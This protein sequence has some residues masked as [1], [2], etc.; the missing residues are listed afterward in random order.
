MDNRFAS[1]ILTEMTEVKKLE[2]SLGVCAE[3][4]KPKGAEKFGMSPEAIKSHLKNPY[5]RKGFHIQEG[6]S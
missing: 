3:V 6:H 5:I 1:F 2:K 4:V